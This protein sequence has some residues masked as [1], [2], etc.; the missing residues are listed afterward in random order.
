[1]PRASDFGVSW[2]SIVK[3]RSVEHSAELS[4]PTL[5]EACGRRT[6]TYMHVRLLNEHWEVVALDAQAAWAVVVVVAGA[7]WPGGPGG[8]G[9]EGCPDDLLKPAG[10]AG[11]A[12]VVFSSGSPLS[13]LSPASPPSAAGDSGGGGGG[14][15]G[16]CCS[17]CSC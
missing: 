12:P 7:P 6:A 17:C 4:L 10:M 13:P 8:S 3:I 16:S 1:M 15:I 5:A 14:D 9:S 2:Y 11:A